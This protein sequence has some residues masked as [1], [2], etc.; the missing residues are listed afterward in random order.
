MKTALYSRYS[1]KKYLLSDSPYSF[2]L[3]EL[4]KYNGKNKEQIIK[5]YFTSESDELPDGY[6]IIDIDMYDDYKFYE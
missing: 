4:E 1:K 3:Y 5:E 6:E 2:I